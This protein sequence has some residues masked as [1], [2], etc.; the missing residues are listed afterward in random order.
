MLKIL[1]T[2]SFTRIVKKLHNKD[3][4]DV[5]EAINVVASEIPSGEEKKGDLSGVFVYKFKM[6][7]Q[8][9]LLAYKFQ[10]SKDNPEEV[11]LLAMGSRENFYAYLK[12]EI[13][14]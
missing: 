2:T 11:V 5:D 9:M 13:S 8:E 6:N 14:V 12:N 7:R 10:L 1:S 3:K 4:K